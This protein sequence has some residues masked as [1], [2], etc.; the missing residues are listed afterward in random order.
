VRK[1]KSVFCG[2]IVFIKGVLPRVFVFC[3]LLKCTHFDLVLALSRL[4]LRTRRWHRAP[5]PRMNW[6]S[7]TLS[8][9]RLSSHNAVP[10]S[11]C[12][13]AAVLVI[14]LGDAA[15]ISC[16]HSDRILSGW[17]LPARTNS[18]SSLSSHQTA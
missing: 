13:P 5:W 14:V 17:C 11:A 7:L 10:T 15:V 18:S 6:R 2:G 1:I 9:Y 16:S 12:L 4:R 8:C 3:Q